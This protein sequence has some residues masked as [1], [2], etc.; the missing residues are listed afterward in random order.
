MFGV[1]W[2]GGGREGGRDNVGQNVGQKK[3]DRICSYY[4]AVGE[5]SQQTTNG[6]LSTE[7][8]GLGGC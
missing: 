6:M 7:M 2:E 5:R 3:G 8:L 1:T 4:R